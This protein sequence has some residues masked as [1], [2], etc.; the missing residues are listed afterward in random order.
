A[1]ALPNLLPGGRPVGDDT[2]RAQMAA[3]WNVDALPTESGRDTAAILAAAGSGALDALLVAAVGVDDLPDPAAAVAALDAAPFVVSLELRHSAVTERADVVF[4]VAPV[5]EKAGSFV[6]WEGRIRPFDASLRTNAIPDQRVLTYL[7]DEIG[8]DL[9]LPTASAAAD[10]RARLGMWS[11][12]RDA[13]DHPAPP[14]P[15]PGDGEAVLATWRLLLDNGR[16]QD[17]EP[18]L[19]GTAHAP[20]VRLSAATAAEIGAGAGD[21]VTVSTDRGAIT[22]PLAVTDMADRVAWVPMNSP[23]SV[24]H[25]ALGVTSGAVVSIG[26]GHL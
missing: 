2:A 19:A 26:R 1:G 22:L 17:G 4:P 18:H 11:G 10:E 13:G 20:V 5:V 15:V 9:G 3:A 21:P 25:S 7:A 24:V 12:S 14:A 6:N 8:V 16:L 23:G